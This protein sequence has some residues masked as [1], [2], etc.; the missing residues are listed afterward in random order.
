MSEL[1]A[2]SPSQ[3][4]RWLFCP[5]KRE[6]SQKGWESKYIGKRDLAAC[7]GS[8]FATA[9]AQHNNDI[10]VGVVDRPKLY[11]DVAHHSVEMELNK[12]DDLGRVIP[13]WEQSTANSIADRVA[14]CVEKYVQ[15]PWPLKGWKLLDV[16]Y[17]LPH[18]R[19]RIDLGVDDGEGIA[20]LDYKT[21]M[22]LKKEYFDKEVQRWRDSWAMFHYC[23]SYGQVK[24]VNIDHYY[25]YVIIAEPKF[26]AK[27]LRFNVHPESM[28]R[29]ESSSRSAWKVMAWED[30]GTMAPFMAAKH[31]DEYGLCEYY[32]AC[33]THFYDEN[34]MKEDYVRT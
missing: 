15:M 29:W 17:T 14:K 34:R 13:D 25:I 16:E 28:A 10:I 6:L 23:W 8:A 4:E 1:K 21:K 30:D 19:A 5:I 2:Y 20:V 22:Y 31:A 33:F 12:W 24:G 27:L 9:V 11:G 18:G 7:F 32:K 26:E 3:T